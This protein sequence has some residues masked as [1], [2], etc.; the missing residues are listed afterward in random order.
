MFAK[1]EFLHETVRKRPLLPLFI[2][3]MI[4]VPRQARDKRKGKSTQTTDRFLA[5]FY[6]RSVLRALRREQQMHAVGIS[7][8]GAGETDRLVPP[9]LGKRA[10][11][12]ADRDDLGRDEQHRALIAFARARARA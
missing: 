7:R 2:L 6:A 3:K 9:A 12:G 8:Q 11:Q 5:G 10:A 4:I 1:G